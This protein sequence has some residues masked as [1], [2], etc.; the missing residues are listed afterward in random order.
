MTKKVELTPLAQDKNLQKLMTVKDALVQKLKKNAE[1]QKFFADD[2]KKLMNTVNTTARIGQ[3][4]RERIK[5]LT[6][7]LF[8][9]REEL[10]EQKLKNIATKS[11]KQT[12]EFEFKLENQRLE[13]KGRTLD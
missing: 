8:Q 6:K 10:K 3:K 12:E 4:M 1:A 13:K 11:A 9:A 5:D 2:V 7:K